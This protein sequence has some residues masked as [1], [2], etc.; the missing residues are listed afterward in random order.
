MVINDVDFLAHLDFLARLAALGFGPKARTALVSQGLRTCRDMLNLLSM[1]EVLK[2]IFHLQAEQKD[3]VSKDLTK[4]E[5]KAAFIAVK[6]LKA[7]YL[8]NCYCEVQGQALTAS[9]FRNN[10]METWIGREAEL[11]W[12]KN[13]REPP[14]PS[15]LISFDD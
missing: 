1:T 2:C 14:E 8:W 6:N 4:P 12:S 3:I 5:P 11:D 10:T 9:D 7:F 15:P 13:D